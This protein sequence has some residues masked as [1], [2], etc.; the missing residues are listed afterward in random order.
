[1]QFPRN[2]AS[3]FFLGFDQSPTDARKGLFGRFAFRDIN[4]RTD[5]ARKGAVSVEP[6]YTNVEDATIFTVMPPQSVFHLK[7]NARVKGLRVCFEASVQILGMDSRGPPVFQLV[8]QSAS[9]KIQPDLIE[10]R[11][12][13]IG[14]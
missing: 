2:A 10:K 12:Q 8:F 6:P 7:I 1:V 4:A 5:V 3:F 13:L 14:S 9:S 11:A